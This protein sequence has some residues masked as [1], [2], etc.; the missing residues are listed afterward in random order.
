MPVPAPDRTYM[1]DTVTSAPHS[2][3]VRETK[4]ITSI[5]SDR[6]NHHQSE[7]K[8]SARTEC[9]TVTHVL[10][11]RTTFFFVF[12][13]DIW[14]K[15]E[16]FSTYFCVIVFKYDGTLLHTHPKVLFCLFGL[17][18]ISIRSVV[19][20]VQDKRFASPYTACLS[21]CY[22]LQLTLQISMALKEEFKAYVPEL[23]PLLLPVLNT[24]RSCTFLVPFSRFCS[25][26]LF[27]R[28]RS[29]ANMSGTAPVF[30]M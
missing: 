17:R 23:I 20:S 19:L 25:E 8:L 9:F 21:M 13:K 5:F 2:D 15:N 14:L 26:Q 3:L 30:A 11:L 1:L 27:L 28:C 16:A 29:M 7:L 18:T 22:A 10:Y 4:Y 12:H 6:H 24:D